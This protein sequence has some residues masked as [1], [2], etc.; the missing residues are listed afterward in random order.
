MPSLSKIESGYKHVYGFLSK[1][2]MKGQD[3]Y[4]KIKE[5]SYMFKRIY[6][7]E[8]VFDANPEGD[9]ILCTDEWDKPSSVYETLEEAQTHDDEALCL[10]DW[11]DD[12]GTKYYTCI[13][14]DS[15]EDDIKC[16]TRTEVF[17]R[18]QDVSHN[19]IDDKWH[20][21]RLKLSEE[22]E[23][24][25]FYVWESYPMDTFEF[26]ELYTTWVKRHG[27]WEHEEIDS[28]SDD[29]ETSDSETDDEDDSD[30]DDE[31]ADDENDDDS[32]DDDEASGS[33]D[34]KSE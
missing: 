2:F 15:D 24:D 1:E 5:L 31:D 33:S 18:M 16:V 22:D 12:N 34:N 19:V 11:T 25:C 14:K 8:E 21:L 23:K 27:E 4:S 26:M 32:D 9:L 3:E 29:S 28:S 7:H 13:Y 6:N 30:E 17:E 20:V 10:C